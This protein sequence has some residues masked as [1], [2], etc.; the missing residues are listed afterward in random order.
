MPTWPNCCTVAVLQSAALDVQTLQLTDHLCFKRNQATAT[1]YNALK[2][3]FGLAGR[4]CVLGVTVM[5]TKI[6][7]QCCR[8]LLG[9][10]PEI[11]R[12]NFSHQRRL[13]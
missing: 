6:L 13:E 4:F 11:L 5:Q 8:F 10:I 9:E 3:I 12:G 1:K 7:V 2:L